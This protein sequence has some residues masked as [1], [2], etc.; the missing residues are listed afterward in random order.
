MRDFRG[1][2]E[3]MGDIYPP[4]L[5]HQGQNSKVKD[6]SAGCGM[7]RDKGHTR[8]IFLDMQIIKP[9]PSQ[10]TQ[11]NADKSY[12]KEAIPTRSRWQMQEN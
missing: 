11:V 4:L 12:L 10:I 2:T 3:G 8:V 6:S 5:T 9:C 7:Q 1:G